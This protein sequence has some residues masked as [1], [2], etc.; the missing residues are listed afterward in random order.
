MSCSTTSCSE[1]LGS[2]NTSGLCKKHYRQRWR[3]QPKIKESDS[4]YNKQYREKNPE[5]FPTWRIA[6]KD[7]R[8]RTQKTYYKENRDK[9]LIESKEW[10]RKNHQQVLQ[11]ERKLYYKKSESEEFVVNRRE[12]NRK[13]GK[14]RRKEGKFK[15]RYDNDI[16]FRLSHNLRT[17]TS[18]AIRGYN[19][20]KAGSSV[21]DLG[22]TLAEFIVHLENQFAAQMS[23]DNYGHGKDCWTIDHIKPLSRFDLSIREEFLEAAHY[24]NL[25][26]MWFLDNIKKGNKYD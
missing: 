13:S 20:K 24:T 4:T 21:T 19:K 25:S 26:P 8:A 22:C 3:N 17:R 6:N 1:I 2:K 16:Q 18:A 5:Y 11:S 23:W 7:E 9:I 14:K 10:K 12:I 15:E